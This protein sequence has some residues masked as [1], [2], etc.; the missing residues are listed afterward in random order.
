MYNPGNCTDCTTC[1]GCHETLNPTDSPTLFCMHCEIDSAP[2]LTACNENA[3][4]VLGGAITLNH[5]KC[6]RCMECVDVG[7]LRIINIK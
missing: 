6:N 1:G 5:E 4:E 7:P 2:C 3:F